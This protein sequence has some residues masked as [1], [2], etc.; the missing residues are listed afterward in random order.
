MCIH[1]IQTLLFY[2]KKHFFYQFITF[3]ILKKKNKV[4]LKPISS[5]MPLLFM[6]IKDKKLKLFVASNVPL[7]IIFDFDKQKGYFVEYSLK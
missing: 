2:I 7:F 1:L 3:I 5:D 6:F 4:L